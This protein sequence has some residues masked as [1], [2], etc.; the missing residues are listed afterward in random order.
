MIEETGCPLIK[1]RWNRIVKD[2]K[3]LLDDKRNRGVQMYLQQLSASAA[4][5]YTL[6]KAS[7]I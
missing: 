3:R 2:L 4:S 1:P 5:D 7:K 6:W